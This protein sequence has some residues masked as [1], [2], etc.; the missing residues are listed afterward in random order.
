MLQW[1]K[2]KWMITIGFNL[3]PLIL[4]LPGSAQET[5]KLAPSLGLNLTQQQG[6]YVLGP[7][8]RIRMNVLNEP[9][10]TGEQEVLPDGTLALPLVGTINVKG[11]TLQAASQVVEREFGTYLKHPSVS[12]S[13]VS[14]RSLRITVVGEVN[15]PGSYSISPTKGTRTI[16]ITDST[17]NTL[18]ESAPRV[19]QLIQLAGGI[20]PK[21]NIRTIEVRRLLPSGQEQTY[22][23]NLWEL[24]QKGGSRDDLILFDGD[25][26]RVPTAQTV[27]LAEVAQLSTANFSPSEIKVNVVGEVT[28]PGE[29]KLSPNTPMNGAILAAGGFTTIAER[30]EIQMIRLNPNGSVTS[31]Q[32]PIDFAQNLNEQTNPPLQN[33]DVIVVKPLPAADTANNLELA[34]KP[35]NILL[36]PF[37]GIASLLRIFG[38]RY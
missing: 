13:L 36:E 10:I 20:T 12:F 22:Q 31:R 11:M 19:T 18:Q 5:V 8:D 27:D 4:V 1:I 21:A 15:R 30:S 23:V 28:K 3:I 9:D 34:V 17:V 32:I 25:S 29:L 6:V 7:G 2:S 33:A 16:A 14:G 37:T 38:L 26:I 24:L 35:F